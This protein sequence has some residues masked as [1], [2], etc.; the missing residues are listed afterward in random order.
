MV[1]LAPGFGPLRLAGQEAMVSSSET[2]RCPSLGQSG[3]KTLSANGF[4]FDQLRPD[5]FTHTQG[6]GISGVAWS[7]QP[8][9]RASV[10]FH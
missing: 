8:A 1:L 3:G 5:R 7:G 4:S 9:S 6:I 2:I 10:R